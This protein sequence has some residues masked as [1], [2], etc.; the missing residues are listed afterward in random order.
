MA[1]EVRCPLC[2]ITGGHTLQCNL[3]IKVSAEAIKSQELRAKEKK[4]VFED[5]RVY[6]SALV[7]K[8]E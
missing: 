6:K 4:K 2:G 3:G 1:N 5:K 7:K 8:D